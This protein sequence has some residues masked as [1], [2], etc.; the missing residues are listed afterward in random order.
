[1]SDESAIGNATI[2]VVVADLIPACKRR[3]ATK[4]ARTLI[5]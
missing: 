4:P 5:E 2:L 3:C 1:M